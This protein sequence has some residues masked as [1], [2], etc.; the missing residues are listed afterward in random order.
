MLPKLNSHRRLILGEGPAPANIMIIGES[1]GAKEEALGRP[2]VG[3]AGLLFD[4]L[5][6]RSGILRKMC[7]ITNVIKERPPN[8]NTGMFLKPTKGGFIEQEAFQQY[9]EYLKAEIEVVDPN[10]I[11]ALGNIPLYVLT[12]LT[13]IT[14]YRGSILES[15]LVPGKKVIPVIHPSAAVRQYTWKYFILFDLQRVLEES[16]HRDG[17]VDKRNYRLR[18]TFDETWA[19]LEECLESDLVAFDIEVS[20]TEVSCISFAYSNEDAISIPFMN[21]QGGEYFTLPQ[22]TKV[23]LKIAEILENPDI[24]KVGQN[25]VFDSTFL[26]RKYGIKSRN[27]HDTMIAQ[28]I[29][30]PDFP[31]GL[32][33]ITSIYT[34]MPYY[35]DDG[36]ELFKK[37]SQNNEQFWLYNAKD[38]IVLME[39]FPAQLEELEQKGNLSTYDYQRRLIEPLLFMTERGMRIDTHALSAKSRAVDVELEALRHELNRVVG[40]EINPLSPAQ[41]K[42]YFYEI[43]K[44][45][46]LVNKGKPTTNEGALKRLARR[47]DKEVQ[48]AAQIILQIRQKAKMNG[49]YYKMALDN[50]GRLRSSMNPVGTRYGRLSSSKTIFGTGANV[51]NQPQEMKQFMLP[52][53]G[54]VAYDIDLSQAENRIVAYLGPEPT[55]IDAFET[56]KDIHSRTAALIF[57]IPED[58]ISRERGSSDI[59]GGRQSQRFWGK[60]ANHAF[61]YG[62]GYK[63]FS[64]QVEIPEEEGKF[65]WERYHAAYPGVRKMYAMIQ[66]QLKKD[67]T[68]TNLLGRR[69]TFRDRWGDSLFKEAYAFIPQSSIADKINRHGIIHIYKRQDL[70]K[71]VE[72]LNQIH[73]SIVFQ[74]PI[75]YGWDVHAQILLN[76]KASLEQPFE[77]RGRSFSIPA[78]IEMHPK[79]FKDGDVLTVHQSVD[80]FAD[81]LENTY[82][83]LMKNGDRD[84]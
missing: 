64:Y 35:K 67:R 16:R 38:S 9:K 52:D 1:P 70:Y 68:L 84:E 8:N 73:D 46:P 21:D 43:K 77:W 54:Y 57:G 41:L 53:E 2:F 19:Y 59:G 74:I 40:Y 31:K 82:S 65:I 5:L 81:H 79:N 83:R 58:Q 55:M 11:V 69:Y 12:G 29:L 13:G 28:A 4:D 50:D 27:L 51:Q 37:G 34:K 80:D 25:V 3:S 48:E 76:I 23:W 66:E 36:K 72:L 61:N 33:F 10:V 24:A 26:F 45:R 22:E 6:H 30:Y 14:K 71:P 63:T 62:Q 15:T 32:D 18:P 17:Y 47:K 75:K 20:G 42:E 78:E 49:T 39:A 56:G 60:K 44:E 7:F